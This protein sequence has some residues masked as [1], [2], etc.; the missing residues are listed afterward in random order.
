MVFF[1]CV[2]KQGVRVVDYAT[3]N[4]AKAL[5]IYESV[6]SIS[7]NKTADFTVL[8]SNYDVILTIRE[9]NIIYKA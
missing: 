8:N 3:A 6:G 5:G 9:G 1:F 2:G 4:P 7:E